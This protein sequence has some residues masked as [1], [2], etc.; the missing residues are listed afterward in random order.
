MSDAL[1]AFSHCIA[2]VH[3]AALSPEDWP[4]ALDAA[5]RL[6]DASGIVLTDIDTDTGSP[7]SIQTSGHDPA[8]LVAYAGHYA[9]IDPT[10]AVGLSG[11]PGTVY[12]LRE[13]FADSQMARME[14]FQDFLFAFGIAD[15]MATP[16]DYAPNARLFVSLQRRTR[17]GSFTSDSHE[18]L[19]HFMT[20]MSI[21]KHT[22]S[23][24]RASAEQHV[25]LAAGLDAFAAAIF[26]VDAR[27]QIRHYNAAAGKLLSRGQGVAVRLRRLELGT[28]A[29]NDRLRYAVQVASRT[30]GRATT[31]TLLSASGDVQVLVTPLSP[32]HELNANWREP[33]ALV[34][35]SDAQDLALAATAKLR[36][37]YGLTAAESRLVAGLAEGKT[38][39]QI[40][41]E[42]NVGLSTLR[43]QLKAAFGKTGVNRQ[44]DLVRLVGEL[45]PL[46]AGPE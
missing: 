38:L 46:V 23:R 24:L 2:S 7:R 4:R 35:I 32:A 43:T 37:L 12:H 14:Y 3:Q 1:V 31:L 29:L 36:R 27:E 34:I 30:L 9:A 44:L 28:S 8:L 22:E 41:T 40:A 42:R 16:L 18:L 6:F 19:K 20:Q 33:L 17:A 11:A 5:T 13:H 45:A 21:A 10:I 26:I 25:T 39:S 15:V